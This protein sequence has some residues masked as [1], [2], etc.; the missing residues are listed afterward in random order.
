MD[1]QKNIKHLC[2]FLLF[3][4]FTITSRIVHQGTVGWRDII[5]TAGYSL[6]MVIVF[7][8]FLGKRESAPKK[9]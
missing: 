3:Y 4:S 5:A 9:L 6:A 8:Y 7:W 1:V 2:I